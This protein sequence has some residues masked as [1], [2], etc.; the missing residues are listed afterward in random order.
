M[1]TAFF[2]TFRIPDPRKYDKPPWGLLTIRVTEFARECRAD[3]FLDGNAQEFVPC[4]DIKAPWESLEFSLCGLGSADDAAD[5][6]NR[7]ESVKWPEFLS[8]G[9]VG[10][11]YGLTPPQVWAIAQLT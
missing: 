9:H 3:I 7:I 10:K 2:Y 6:F 11:S 8:R 5:F 4:R 1:D